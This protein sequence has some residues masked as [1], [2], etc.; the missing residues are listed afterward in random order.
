MDLECRNVALDSNGRRDFK[1]DDWTFEPRH[2]WPSAIWDRRPF[3]IFTTSGN[4]VGKIRNF[5]GHIQIH[6]WSPA[7]TNVLW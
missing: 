1:V 6:I 2:K 7:Y 3:E 5:F 4:Q